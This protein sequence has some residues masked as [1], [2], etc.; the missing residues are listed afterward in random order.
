MQIRSVA[1]SVTSPD[2]SVSP[3]NLRCV[4]NVSLDRHQYDDVCVGGADGAGGLRVVA[5]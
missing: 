5:V 2:S 1:S 4:G 3:V